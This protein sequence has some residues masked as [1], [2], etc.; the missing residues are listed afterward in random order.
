M[1][2]LILPF[3]HICLTA[4]LT[5][6]FA[7][8]LTAEQWLGLPSNPS[9]LTVQREG[10]AKFTPD[11]NATVPTAT[12]SDLAAGTGVRLRGTVTP[13]VTGAYTFAVSGSN[14]VT[15]W[16]SSNA[17]R[18][19]K[20]PI[21]WQHEPSSPLQWNKF[22]S[23]QSAPVTLTAGISYYIEAIVMSD[24]AGGHL[25]L[26]WKTPGGSTIDSIPAGNLAPLQPDA[27]DTNDNNLPDSW[28]TQ[29]GL[30]ASTI[31][32]ARSEYADPDN[33]GITN[34]SE[35]LLT[36]GPLVKN[37]ISNGLTRDTWQEIQGQS[38]DQLKADRS[39]FHFHPNAST[40]IPGI[41]ETRPNVIE[42]MNY[43]A[44]YRGFLIAPTT[45]AYR[46][47][48]AGDDDAELWFADGTAKDPATNAALT[49]RFGKQLL[50]YIRNSNGS[51]TSAHRDFDLLPSQ[52]T[53]I[54]NLTAGQRYY[55]EVLHKNESITANHVSLAWQPPGQ[56]RV[57][58]PASAFLS[59]VPEDTDRDNDSL[60]DPWETSKTLSI[61]DNGYTSAAEGQYGDHD[62]DGLN[63]LL[64]YQYKTNPTVA[65]TDGDNIPDFY[66][67]IYSL[68]PTNPADGYP[69][70]VG[71]TNSDGIG[72][73][74]AFLLGLSPLLADADGDGV[75][76]IND[77]YPH[78]P[79]R[80]TNP[81]PNPS[82]TTKP[83]VAIII[84][85]GAQYLTGP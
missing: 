33:D 57:I 38:L 54:V 2:P 68:D 44:R 21:A 85:Q 50:A 8:A 6:P 71:D 14:N 34:F 58:V 76:D 53:R 25:A 18:F 49:S 67:I 62:S 19:G 15:L 56:A 32:G 59:D 66:E 81:V 47:W 43:G 29:T 42:G 26:G 63:N 69:S 12:F 52:R 20:Q 73:A 40:H 74:L 77:A 82:D 7:R 31:P 4:L 5:S 27:S 72:D 70:M 84:P 35:Y 65:D 16:L 30:A 11:S 9:V 22:T 79:S 37:T 51:F 78:D 83:I 64:E 24:S 13:T 10:I 48:I 61:T 75:P 3:S 41:D 17:S 23:Q 80:S 60:P 45:G 1:K 39:R 28:E 46:L 36:S 55:I